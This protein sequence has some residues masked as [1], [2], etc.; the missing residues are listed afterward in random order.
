MRFTAKKSTVGIERVER[1]PLSPKSQDSIITRSLTPLLLDRWLKK[2]KNQSPIDFHFGNKLIL[3][4]RE[5][6]KEGQNPLKPTTLLIRKFQKYGCKNPTKVT[7]QKNGT[8]SSS[9][10]YS[11]ERNTWE[12]TQ[13]PLFLHFL[14]FLKFLIHNWWR[15]L[16]NFVGSVFFFFLIRLRSPLLDCKSFNLQ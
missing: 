12:G 13:I 1:D 8:S 4:K 3:R 14:K 11:S 16:L 6:E 2:I 15:V 7:E 9:R 5:R 10:S